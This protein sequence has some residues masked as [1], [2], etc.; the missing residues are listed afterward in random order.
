M[1]KNFK[2]IILELDPNIKKKLKALPQ[3]EDF[4]VKVK[5][6]FDL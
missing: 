3:L 5:E 6:A 1:E 4:I 2:I